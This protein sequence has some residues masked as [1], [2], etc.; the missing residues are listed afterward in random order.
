MLLDVSHRLTVTN[1]LLSL[2]SEWSLMLVEIPPVFI[3]YVSVC[4]NL[5]GHTS[6]QL[7]QNG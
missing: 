1:L 6:G 7:L 2:A 5:V 3:W 4:C